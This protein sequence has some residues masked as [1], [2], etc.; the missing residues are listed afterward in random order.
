MRRFRNNLADGGMREDDLL[1][2]LDAQLLLDQKDRAAFVPIGGT[3][4]FLLF[5]LKII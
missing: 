3:G 4:L 5:H 1:D 2:V